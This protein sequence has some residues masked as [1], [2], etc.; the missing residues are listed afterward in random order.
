MMMK[1]GNKVLA[2]SLMAQVRTRVSSIR[3]NQYRMEGRDVK[4]T[5]IRNYQ[6]SGYPCGPCTHFTLTVIY[7]I[8]HFVQASASFS[9]QPRW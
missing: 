3:L 4:L 5:G 1:G 9:S 8:R 2:R 7:L 6:N